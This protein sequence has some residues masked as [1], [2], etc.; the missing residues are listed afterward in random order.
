M[1]LVALALED[2]IIEKI[3]VPVVVEV[4]P[5]EDFVHDTRGMYICE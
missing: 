3:Q 4:L 1:I 5:G 2:I